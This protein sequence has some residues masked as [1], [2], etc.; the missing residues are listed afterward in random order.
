MFT[1]ELVSSISVGVR[2]VALLRRSALIHFTSQCFNFTLVFLILGCKLIQ[3]I[4]ISLRTVST[5]LALTLSPA[6]PLDTKPLPLLPDFTLVSIRKRRPIGNEIC[7]DGTISIIDA[8]I[9]ITTTA[10]ACRYARNVPIL[11]YVLW[12]CRDLCR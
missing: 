5:L 10:T 12:K 6:W 9:P 8:G 3:T 2:L 11:G 1:P 4:G 7:I